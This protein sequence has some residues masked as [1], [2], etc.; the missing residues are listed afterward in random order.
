MNLLYRYERVN[1]KIYKSKEK[2]FNKIAETLG[3]AGINFLTKEL[4][5]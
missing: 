1:T 5:K 2:V 3:E 4:Q